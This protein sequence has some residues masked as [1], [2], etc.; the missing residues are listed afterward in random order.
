MKHLFVLGILFFVSACS[1]ET[2]VTATT[3]AEMKAKEAQEAKKTMDRVQT[4]L[5]DAMK[6]A[7]Q[8]R[9]AMD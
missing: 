7:E 5:D 3:V 4:Q 6:Q 2:A 9:R 8:R 1:V